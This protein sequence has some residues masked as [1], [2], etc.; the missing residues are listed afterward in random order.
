VACFH[1]IFG[2]LLFIAFLVTGQFMRHDFPDKSL[3]GED[4]RL[5]MRSRHIYILLA[6][7]GQILLGVYF[8]PAAGRVQKALQ[9][10]GSVLLT[11]SGSLLL[12]AFVYESYTIRHFS[13]ISRYGL[14][15]ALGGTA[16]HL[17][18]G[19]RLKS[20]GNE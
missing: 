15:T 5:L 19:F 20:N 17:F 6:A 7:L 2:I 10:F 13:D 3:I 18:G 4:L 14:Y 12:Y 9:L 8:R 16:F 1:L 11:I